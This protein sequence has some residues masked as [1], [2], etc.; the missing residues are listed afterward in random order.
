MFLYVDY[1]FTI[2]LRNNIPL[3]ILTSGPFRTRVYVCVRMGMLLVWKGKKKTHLFKTS[4]Q[5]RFLNLYAAA[6]VQA[7]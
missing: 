3:Q 7:Q 1:M 2:F 6:D 4:H 5:A